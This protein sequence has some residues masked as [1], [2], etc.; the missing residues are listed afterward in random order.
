MNI[1]QLIYRNFP[2]LYTDASA[3]QG[4]EGCYTWE[5]GTEY[6]YNS[7]GMRVEDMILVKAECQAREKDIEGAM[8]TLN[9]LRRYRVH[10]DAYQLLE[11][12]TETE[13]MEYIIRAALIEHLFTYTNFFDLKR[14]NTEDVYKRNITRTV[15]GVTYTLVPDSPYWVIPFPTDATQ[16]NSSLT[17]NF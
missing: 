15:N 17:Q 5:N 1:L 8:N 16:Y 10:P 11:A 12:E 4:I 3:T 9:D 13:A 6:V 7:S 14:W 2:D